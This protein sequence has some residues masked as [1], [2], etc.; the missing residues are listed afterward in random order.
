MNKTFVQSSKGLSHNHHH[1][2]EATL[3]TDRQENAMT[4]ALEEASPYFGGTLRTGQKE[5]AMKGTLG[6]KSQFQGACQC[7]HSVASQQRALASIWPRMVDLRK[8]NQNIKSNNSWGNY[9][10][11][12]ITVENQVINYKI[13]NVSEHIK[14]SFLTSQSA[15]GWLVAHTQN[16]PHN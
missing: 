16:G 8:P 11:V 6:P 5:N 3:S 4:R 15:Y 7:S 2:L 14:F 10:Q 12:D 9:V 1:G 13:N